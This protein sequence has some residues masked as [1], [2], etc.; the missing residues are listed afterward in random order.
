MHRCMTWGGVV[1]VPGC[2]VPCPL[3]GKVPLGAS[4]CRSRFLLLSPVYWQHH[5]PLPNNPSLYNL[6]SALINQVPP[7]SKTYCIDKVCWDG[8]VNLWH[9]LGVTIGHDKFHG[10]AWNRRLPP[11]KTQQQPIS[12]SCP[13]LA[14]TAC[15]RSVSAYFIL[16][17]VLPST[18]HS[19]LHLLELIAL[20][21]YS[22]RLLY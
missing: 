4:S 13:S 8:K 17:T 11:G 14:P 6:T 1:P 2:C 3:L 21:P 22:N 7:T 16:A 10:K 5:P 20:P 19:L 15:L 18:E 12:I 9:F